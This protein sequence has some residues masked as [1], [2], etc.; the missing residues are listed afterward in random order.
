MATTGEVS[1]R[2]WQKK[3]KNCQ[4]LTVYNSEICL[5]QIFTVLYEYSV[6]SK[7]K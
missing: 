7:C 4:Q 3:I 1:R 2:E 6:N 5:K